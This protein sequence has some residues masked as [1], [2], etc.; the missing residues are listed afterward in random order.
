MLLLLLLVVVVVVGAAAPYSHIAPPAAAAAKAVAPLRCAV[1]RIMWHIQYTSTQQ[2]I[3]N[4][5][6]ATS[7]SSSCHCC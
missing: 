3:S 1:P 7:T 2:H 4:T 6:Q 5:S